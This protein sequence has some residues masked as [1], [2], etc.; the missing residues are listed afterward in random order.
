[1]VIGY[2]SARRDQPGLKTAAEPGQNSAL[3]QLLAAKPVELPTHLMVA[4]IH[5][6]CLLSRRPAREAAHTGALDIAWPAFNE[7]GKADRR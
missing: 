7:E 2:Q 6:I 3:L 1:M 4:A 5:S